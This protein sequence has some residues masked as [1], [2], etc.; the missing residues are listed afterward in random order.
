GTLVLDRSK[1][2]NNIASGGPNS[3]RAEGGGLFNVG[4]AT[5]SFSTIQSNSALSI[6]STFAEGGGVDNFLGGVLTV[7]SSLIAYNN[8]QNGNPSGGGIYTIGSATVRNS[9]IV[10]NKS[11]SLGSFGGGIA[12]GLGGALTVTNSTISGNDCPNGSGGGIDNHKGEHLSVT[13]SI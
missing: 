7:D 4:T 5:I 12:I 8:A 6:G 3:V 2:L 10:L 11:L 13:D 1:L 9:S